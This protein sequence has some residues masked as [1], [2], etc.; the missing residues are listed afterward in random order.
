LSRRLGEDPFAR[1]RNQ[2]TKAA[3]ASLPA[4]P[5][6]GVEPAVYGPGIRARGSY[7]DVLFQRRSGADDSSITD[8]PQEQVIVQEA[9]EISEISETPEFRE[10]AADSVAQPDEGG[11][12]T[13]EE[14]QAP[15]AS[16]IAEDQPASSP[17]EDV[18]SVEPSASV[19]EPASQ[20]G[21]SPEADQGPASVAAASFQEQSEG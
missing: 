6:S 11:A 21:G 16:P 13:A 10:V 3:A 17:V 12:S 4:S 14:A 7:N 18:A 2:A 19:A 5:V 20:G 15:V 9:P 1:A 8:E